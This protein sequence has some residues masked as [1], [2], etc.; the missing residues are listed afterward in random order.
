MKRHGG[1]LWFCLCLVFVPAMQAAKP[2]VLLII[3]DDLVATLGC[4]GFPEAK[5]PNLDALAARG[6]RFEHA[7]CQ[8]SRRRGGVKTRNSGGA[9]CAPRN[10]VARNG[11]RD[12]TGSSSTITR[13]IPR[14]I[15]I[16]RMIRST[17][18]C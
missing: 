18:S 6:V 12:A 3:S 15:T 11:T 5:T 16:W 7:Y 13:P 9:V 17:R 2:N 8:L 4:Y 14:S 1:A 10:G